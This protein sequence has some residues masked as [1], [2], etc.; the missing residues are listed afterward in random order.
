MGIIDGY[1]VY[2]F[3]DTQ[4]NTPETLPS[5]KYFGVIL[6][7]LLQCYGDICGKADLVQYLIDAIFPKDVF[8]A[9]KAIKESPHYVS[10]R[11]LMEKTNLSSHEILYA[12]K[13][14]LDHSVIRQDT[15]SIRAGH[16]P[17]EL[18]AFFYTVD[19]PC[20]RKLLESILLALSSSPSEE[21]LSGDAEG[22]RHFVY[23]SRIER[24][25][26]NRIEAIKLHGYKCMACGFD[27]TEA[28][29]DLGRNYIEVHHTTPLAFQNG[30]CIVNP[31]TDL[32]C[33]CSNCHRMVHRK[34]NTVL[35]VD[36]LRRLLRK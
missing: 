35:P 21:S 18:D 14:L 13:W 4:K 12:V 7:G 9:A 34:G 25:A 29:G 19:S 30:E 36:E 11:A 5:Y 3:T 26:R 2:S 28:Y 33:L 8:S 6:D 17:T 15:R 24:S 20:A 1:P 23:A 16:E 27:F 31:L 22:G 32:V 10:G